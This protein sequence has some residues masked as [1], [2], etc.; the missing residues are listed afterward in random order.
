MRDRARSRLQRVVEL[1][2]QKE[3]SEK[4]RKAKFDADAARLAADERDRAAALKA[5]STPAAIQIAE[6]DLKESMGR[7]AKDPKKYLA[8]NDGE[9]PSFRNSF[10]FTS[11]LGTK[12][13]NAAE[14]NEMKLVKA[15]GESMDRFSMSYPD[16]KVKNGYGSGGELKTAYRG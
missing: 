4:E 15:Y 7:Y 16:W 9:L 13:E 14:A 6:R 8:D 3:L 12:R 2:T 10:R 5:G 11:G 1:R